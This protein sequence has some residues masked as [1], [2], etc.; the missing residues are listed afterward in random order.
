MTQYWDQRFKVPACVM[1]SEMGGEAVLL[2]LDTETYLG[3]DDT[4]ARMWSVLSQ[5]DS[6]ETAFQQLLL[7]Y[8]VESQLLR[9]DLQEFVAQ[10]KSHGLVEID[11]AQ[12]S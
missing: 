10:L 2:N 3:L 9:K 11:V 4:G 5:S 1:V 8:D 7:E 6:L 12:I